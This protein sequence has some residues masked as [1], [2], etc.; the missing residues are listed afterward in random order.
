M[1]KPGELRR[2]MSGRGSEE[3]RRRVWMRNGS[4]EAKLFGDME[5]GKVICRE[6]KN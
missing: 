4:N 1:E 3:M 5:V 2:L 6:L